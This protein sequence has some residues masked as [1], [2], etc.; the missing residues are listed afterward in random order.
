MNR[1]RAIPFC[2]I[3]L[4]GFCS[5]ATSQTFIWDK[6]IENYKYTVTFG[7]SDHS[8]SITS[9]STV[10]AAATVTSRLNIPERTNSA[11]INIR[12]GTA[13]LYWATTTISG[14]ITSASMAIGI[15]DSPAEA[16]FYITN[17]ASLGE[18]PEYRMPSGDTSILYLP[19]NSKS[20]F[21]DYGYS[22]IPL[23][24]SSKALVVWLLPVSSGLAAI[25]ND[26][27]TVEV[28]FNRE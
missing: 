15:F 12:C 21:E 18:V 13:V 22:T 20:K 23:T 14:D 17:H 2:F 27:L 28:L 9:A 1:I 7:T 10:V 5:D 3:L 11:S 6:Q 24:K 26:A 19:Y 8:I 4:L 16:D 25:N